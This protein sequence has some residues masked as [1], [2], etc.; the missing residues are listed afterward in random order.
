MLHSPEA[1]GASV[2]SIRVIAHKAAIW[3][4]GSVANT[5]ALL[6]EPPS[7]P[8]TCTLAD[9]YLVTG[10]SIGFGTTYDYTGTHPMHVLLDTQGSVASRV[11]NPEQAIKQ[12]IHS[13][14]MPPCHTHMVMATNLT[15]AHLKRGPNMLP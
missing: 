12:R 5:Q 7:S 3:K 4:E 6:R 8:S 1:S 2:S 10:N 9:N 15:A 14:Y 11:C 13:S